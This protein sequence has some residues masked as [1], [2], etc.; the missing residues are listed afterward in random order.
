M[1]YLYSLLFISL[2]VSIAFSQS[3]PPGTYT[4]NNKK[5]ISLFEDGKK[6]LDI[7]NYEKA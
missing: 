1:R 2:A 4:S 7:R 3:L 6:M 5:A